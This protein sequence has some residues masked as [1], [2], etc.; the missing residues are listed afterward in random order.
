[1]GTITR[2]DLVELLQ[3]ENGFSRQ[4]AVDFLEQML[5]L[6]IQTLEREDSLKLSGFGTFGVRSKATRVGRNPL[7]GEEALI[8][9]RCVPFFRPSRFLREEVNRKRKEKG[10]SA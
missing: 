3:K 8:S 7:T 9:A 2:A 4:E 5:E 6:F 1:M 10:T